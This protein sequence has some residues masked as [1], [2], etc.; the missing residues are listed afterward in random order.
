MKSHD[1]RKEIR[2]KKK[3]ERRRMTMTLLRSHFI[4]IRT[5]DGRQ[6]VQAPVWKQLSTID[7]RGEGY[8]ADESLRGF[9]N[10]PSDA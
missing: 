4:R 5:R 6:C 10:R 7:G 8:I 3:K 9:Y 1:D 2:K